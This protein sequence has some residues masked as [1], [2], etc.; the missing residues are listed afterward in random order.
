MDNIAEYVNKENISLLRIDDT[1]PERLHSCSYPIVYKCEYMY[2][3][4]Q[5]RCGLCCKSLK[6]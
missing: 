4:N 5:G 2:T 1:V 6:R 3:R